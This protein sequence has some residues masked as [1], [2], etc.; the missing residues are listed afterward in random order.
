MLIPLATVRALHRDDTM[1]YRT[2]WHQPDAADA[3]QF[4]S[5]WKQRDAPISVMYTVSPKRGPLIDGDN[6]VKT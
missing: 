1:G 5:Q 3:S 6:S 4:L 2:R